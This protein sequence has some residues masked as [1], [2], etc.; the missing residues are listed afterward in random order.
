VGLLTF[1]PRAA[2]SQEALQQGASLQEGSLRETRGDGTVT[3]NLRQPQRGEAPRYPRDVIIGELGKGNAPGAAWNHA[4]SL[5]DALVAGSAET[6]V[7]Q[8]EGSL[9]ER[10]LGE[11]EAVAPSRCHIGGGR[12]EADGCVSFLVRFLGREKTVAGDLYLRPQTP[13]DTDGKAA[14]GTWRLDDLSLGEPR[15]ISE[16]KGYKYDFS[17]Y[18][19][20]Y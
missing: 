1:L 6:P 3:L 15:D 14:A 13:P 9:A 7:L 2:F 5:C 16:Q 20:F 11:L 4:V 18:E 19:R 12:L 17:P 8:A 10:C